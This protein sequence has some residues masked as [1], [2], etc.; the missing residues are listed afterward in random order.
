M[1]KL[2]PELSD[3]TAGLYRNAGDCM[4]ISKLMILKADNKKVFYDYKKIVIVKLPPKS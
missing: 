2:L 4:K 3:Y 1:E